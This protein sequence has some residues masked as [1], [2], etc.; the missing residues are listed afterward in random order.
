LYLNF[1][2]CNLGRLL[3][4]VGESLID[5]K[6]LDVIVFDEIM[7]LEQDEGIVHV[8]E[9]VSVPAHVQ[10]IMYTSTE[11]EDKQKCFIQK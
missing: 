3:D 5:F 8:V 6:N 11:L 7:E 9:H 4:Y 2:I 1:F 10:F